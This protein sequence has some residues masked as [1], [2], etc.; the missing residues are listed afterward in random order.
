LKDISTE[1]SYEKNLEL[2]ND[3]TLALSTAP[4]LTAGTESVIRLLCAYGDF[5]YG[6]CWMP[7]YGQPLAKLK[8]SWGTSEK[9]LSMLLACKDRTLNI[10]TDKP[11]VFGTGKWYFSDCIQEDPTIRRR[12]EAALCGLHTMLTVPLIYR[13][14]LLCLFALYAQDER[15]HPGLDPDE[16]QVLLSKLGGELERRKSNE[17]LDR[18]FSLSPDLMSIISFDGYTKKT[19][20]AFQQLFGYT[21]EEI[22]SMLV[23]D[24][25]HPDDLQKVQDAW[26]KAMQGQAHRNLELRY[27][28]KNGE[29]RWLSCTTQTVIEENLIYLNGREISEQKL[30]IQEL[31]LI[32]LGIENTSDAIG[33]AT[34]MENAIY[35]NKSFDKLLGWTLE[36][37]NAIGWTKMFVNPQLPYDIV[38][39]LIEKNSWEG[40]I[41]M[42]HRNGN[43]LDINLRAN[44]LLNQDGTP[45]YLIGVYRDI[46]EQKRQLQ[47]L[48]LIKLAVE[49]TSDAIGIAAN[50]DQALYLNKGFQKLLGWTLEE[51][52]PRGWT[53]TFVDPK[54]PTTIVDTIMER[55]SWEGD[56]EMYHRNGN[57]L[58]I[59][60]RANA[61]LNQDGTPRYL[62][63]VCRDITE[64][65]K[66][67]L[68]LAKLSTAIKHSINE[69]YIIT[70]ES[71]HFSYVNARALNNLGYRQSEI[72]T[73]RPLKI[74]PEY[75]KFHYRKMFAL[76]ISG[77]KKALHFQTYHTRKDGSRYPVEIHL[78]PFQFKQEHAVMAS[79]IDITERLQAEEEL[80][81]SHERYQ[82]V[83]RATNDAIWDFDQISQTCY[84]GEG[85]RTLFGH[86]YGESF[87]GM[88]VWAENI[89]Y[90]DAERVIGNF[91]EVVIHKAKEW[92]IEYRFRCADGNY[93]FVKDRGYVIY[94]AAGN[95]VR[96]TAALSDITEQKCNEALLQEFNNELE[97]KRS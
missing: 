52:N 82:L 32:R 93:K 77:R 97:Q 63:G 50:I 23:L 3:T 73:L 47:E 7:L 19:N 80:R 89:H 36:E 38:D 21:E 70:P 30:R 57:I 66:A 16:L 14:Q 20:P 87:A 31:E 85:F 22:K 11:E 39:I 94:D 79:V 75:A 65:K 51:L 67:Q 17:E 18:F 81:I 76:L 6:E 13:N 83:T 86:D 1:V 28:C 90:Q 92:V 71:G 4:T 34:D 10:Q 54:T 60:M 2:L 46:T 55:G 58:D 5:Q 88:E 95:A 78:S 64:Q 35:V 8:S 43:I 68:E 84:Y 9:F 49:N 74:N 56:I 26:I 25:V 44:A 33:M 48:E 69:V 59:N 24:L 62:I 37:L 91:H 45:R 41:E 72:N 96:M 42:Y 27:R 15:K 12:P 61:V 53:T 29:Y 40:D